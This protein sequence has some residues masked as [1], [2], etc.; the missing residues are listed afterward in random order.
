MALSFQFFQK[1]RVLVGA[2]AV[3][4]LGELADHMGAKKALV[5][6]DP[7]MVATGIVDKITSALKAG[8]KEYVVFDENEP[9]PP[10]AACEKGYE[11]CKAENCDFIIGIGGGSNM[12]CAKGINILRFNPGP[13][14]QYANF[15]KPFDVGTGLIMI[16]TTA[17]T[18]S[19]MSDGSILSDE[20][21]I[22]QNFIAD[23]AYADYAILD[24]ELMTG[25]PPKLTAF[26]GL[27]A[28]AHAI[29]SVTG[30]LTSPY[31][32][33]V[34]EQTC[35]DI[36][37]Y[38]PRA[39][40][41]GNDVKAREKMA[42]ASNI[43]GFELVYGH[44]NGGHS[45]AQT[46]GGFFNVP[47]GAACGYVT[48]WITEFNAIA[49]PELVKTMLE[50]MGCEFKD[51]ATPEEIGATAREFLLDFVYNKCKVPP[52]AEAFPDYDEAKFEE[53]AEVC[54]KEFFQMFNPRK[55]SKDDCLTIIKNMYAYK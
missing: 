30:T 44:T 19:E 3:N 41:N 21:H 5:V 34:C 14:I 48:P 49:V 26:T 13:L 10:I 38:L 4:Q 1:T 53:C 54:E 55:M 23:G 16:P 17:G 29:E 39:V 24:P 28:L 50:A 46:V 2:G 7:G 36:A 47:H 52:M 45:I 40:A 51:G 20:N 6:A 32:E 42:V 8:G 27:D 18:G 9:N 31:L 43:G 15:A 12:D 33:F 35:R 25:M 22:K 37:R 11:V